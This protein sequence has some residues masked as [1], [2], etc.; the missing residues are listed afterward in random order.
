MTE[1]M[2]VMNAYRE[3]EGHAYECAP[4]VHKSGNP[5]SVITVTD[6][7]GSTTEFLV[8]VSAVRSVLLADGWAGESRPEVKPGWCELPVEAKYPGDC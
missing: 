4:I 5:T 6:K 1:L 7:D 2:N 8:I 3:E